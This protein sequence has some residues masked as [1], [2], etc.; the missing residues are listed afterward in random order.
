MLIYGTCHF[1]CC[2][3]ASHRM[4]CRVYVSVGCLSVPSIAATFWSISTTGA[5]AQQ[6]A[7]LG[8]RAGVRYWLISPGFWA[9]AMA[10]IILR[11][12]LRCWTKIPSQ[13]SEVCPNTHTRLTAFFRDYPGE[14]VPKRW[15]QS[16][17]YWGR[18]ETVSGSGISWAVCKSAPRCRQ[19]T[20]PAPHHSVFT[21]RMPF[22][23]PNQQR[24]STEVYPKLFWN[25]MYCF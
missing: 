13:F 15:N 12:E 20:T 3:Q 14:P 11:A 7:P 18:Q 10:S 4:Q 6:K 24:Q 25:I 16:G 19:I 17:F 22:L 1:W 9:A 21:D 8:S 23:P 2:L 5:G